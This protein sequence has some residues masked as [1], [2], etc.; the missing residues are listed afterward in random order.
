MSGP[1]VPAAQYMPFVVFELLV[2]S[3][4][5]ETSCSSNQSSSAGKNNIL[6][7]HKTLDLQGMYKNLFT[8]TSVISA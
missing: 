1:A 4:T 2:Y 3:S 6:L 5:E 8:V 7:Q